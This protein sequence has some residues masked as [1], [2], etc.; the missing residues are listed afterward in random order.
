VASAHSSGDNSV[1]GGIIAGFPPYGLT[2][3]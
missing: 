1:D 3:P 2:F